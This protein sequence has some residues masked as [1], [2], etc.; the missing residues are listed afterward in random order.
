MHTLFFTFRNEMKQK[1]AAQRLCSVPSFWF[2]TL[3][4]HGIHWPGYQTP[5]TAQFPEGA[6]SETSLSC[7]GKEGVGE[8][9]LS[10]L[11]VFSVLVLAGQA[12]VAVLK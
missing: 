12:A 9:L 5:H 10:V 8:R 6:R 2:Q 11:V 7:A 1:Q 3:T 4:D